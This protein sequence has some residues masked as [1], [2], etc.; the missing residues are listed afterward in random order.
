MADGEYRFE[1]QADS[2]DAVCAVVDALLVAARHHG[3]PVEVL[4][5]LFSM[6]DG[7]RASAFEGPPLLS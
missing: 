4:A 2:R 7:L 6:R 3:E 5:F 1:G